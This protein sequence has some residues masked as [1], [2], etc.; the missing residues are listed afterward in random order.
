MQNKEHFVYKVE[1]GSIADELDIAPG[2][3]LIKINDNQILDVFDYHYGITDEYL[4]LL[5]EKPNGDQWEIEIEKGINEDLGI[6]F[7][8]GLMDS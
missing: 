8:D 7:K 5:I 3:K 1:A 2:D 4:V 6:E